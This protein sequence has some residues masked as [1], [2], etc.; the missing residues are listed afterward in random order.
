M[1]PAA[2]MRSGR[3]RSRRL[4]LAAAICVALASAALTGALYGQEAPE[5]I[6][7]IPAVEGLDQAKL[8]LGRRLF[9]DPRLSGGDRIA[10]SSCH[11]LKAGGEDGRPRAIGANGEP[12]E[13]NT[14]SLFNSAWNF[15]LSWR[16]NF[17]G[18]AAETEA[19]LL[20]PGFMNARWDDLLPK[21]RRDEGY[22]RSFGALYGQRWGQAEIL[23]TLA[24]FERSLVTPNARFDKYLRGDTS[25]ISADEKRGYQLFSSYGCVSCHQGRNVGGNLFEKF[26]IFSDPYSGRAAATPADL[27]RYT[28]T[29]KEED[30]YVF[31]VPSLRNVAVTAPYFHDG[32]AASLDDAV[33][34]M[35]R[36]Q[37]GRDLPCGDVAL[38]VAFLGTL[39]GEYQGHPLRARD[40]G[41]R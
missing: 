3:R 32:S 37:L 33:S 24:E 35:G 40:P 39:T 34:A 8:E 25:A 28:I 20:D 7:P 12:Q 9:E 21:L 16:G 41:Q 19:V 1:A 5:P 6:T 31:R 23:A 14:L 18:F 17:R 30:R 4:Q 27:G 13:F 11:D 15:R 38:I 36:F 10:C 2:H 26:G 22:R 29:G